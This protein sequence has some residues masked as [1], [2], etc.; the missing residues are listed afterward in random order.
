MGVCSEIHVINCTRHISHTQLS[1]ILTP[2]E[3]R[4]KAYFWRIIIF[5]PW[6]YSL[7]VRQSEDNRN[8]TF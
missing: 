7:N 6:S 3:D 4:I 5:V 8:D 2:S 1:N